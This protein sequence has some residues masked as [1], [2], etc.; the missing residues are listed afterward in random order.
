MDAELRTRQ[1]QWARFHEWEAHHPH[2]FDGLSAA[3][4]W[5]EETWQLAREVG[6]LPAVPR[7]DMGKVQHLA[8]LQARLAGLQWRK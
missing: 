5:Y 8:K 2:E 7:L 3:W 1:A 6:A 4:R